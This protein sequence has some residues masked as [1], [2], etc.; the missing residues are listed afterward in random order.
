[1]RKHSAP[2]VQ[3]K[4]AGCVRTLEAFSRVREIGVTRVGTG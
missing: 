3:V 1:M 2:E 4:A